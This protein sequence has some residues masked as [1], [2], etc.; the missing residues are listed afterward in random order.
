MGARGIVELSGWPQELI[1]VPFA[2]L[3]DYL[4]PRYNRKEPILRTTQPLQVL[5]RS[6]C[7]KLASITVDAGLYFDGASVPWFGRLFSLSRWGRTNWQMVGAITHDPAYQGEGRFPDV[8]NSDNRWLH[9]CLACDL[10]RWA[11]GS[12]AKTAA[13]YWALRVFARGKMECTSIHPHRIM[14]VRWV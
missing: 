2:E 13:M 3:P 4:K 10:W 7:G 8:S 6:P 11:G 9:D 12:T 5:W 1:V 14:E